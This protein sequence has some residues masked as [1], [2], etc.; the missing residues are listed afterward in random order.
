MGE[1]TYLCISTAIWDFGQADVG[2]GFERGE[3]S[4]THERIRID[5]KQSTDD[6]YP[7]YRMDFTTGVQISSSSTSVHVPSGS[8][9]GQETG[10]TGFIAN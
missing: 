7:G 10:S 2:K 8:T 6:T 5:T 1:D 3:H 9:M 4:I